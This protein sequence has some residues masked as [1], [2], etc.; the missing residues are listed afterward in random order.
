MSAMRGRD[1][2]G[3]TGEEIIKT[4]SEGMKQYK[5]FKCMEQFLRVILRQWRQ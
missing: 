3:G 5:S 1:T 4:Q 2:D